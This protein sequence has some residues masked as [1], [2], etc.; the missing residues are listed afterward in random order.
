MVYGTVVLADN[1]GWIFAAYNSD[2]CAFC[3][4]IQVAVSEITNQYHILH[5]QQYWTETE[6]KFLCNSCHHN[7]RQGLQLIHK[8]QNLAFDLL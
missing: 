7:I 1:F 2:T 5:S 8:S 6:L 4:G 3:M